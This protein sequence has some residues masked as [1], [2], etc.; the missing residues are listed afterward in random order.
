MILYLTPTYTAYREKQF[1]TGDVLS[2]PPRFLA[3]NIYKLLIVKLFPSKCYCLNSV[4]I[5]YSICIYKNHASIKII[6]KPTIFFLKKLKIA[7]LF[8]KQIS[9]MKLHKVH[10][11]FWGEIKISELKDI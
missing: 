3:I 1:Y 2:E 8:S 11:F 4:I 9:C 6:T 5:K 10:N 7:L